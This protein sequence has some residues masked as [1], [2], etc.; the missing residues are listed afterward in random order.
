LFLLDLALYLPNASVSP[1]FMVLY[2]FIFVAF[3]TLPLNELSMVQLALDLVYFMAYILNVSARIV[4]DLC[5]F[6]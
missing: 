1:V 4:L 6:N 3:F 5:I 2:L